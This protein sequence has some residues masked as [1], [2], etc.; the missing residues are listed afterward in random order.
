MHG[1][2]SQSL[3]KILNSYP[4]TSYVV[5]RSQTQKRKSQKGKEI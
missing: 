1:I 4:I 5:P 3:Q 2:T